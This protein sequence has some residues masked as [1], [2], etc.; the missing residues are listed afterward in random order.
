MNKIHMPNDLKDWRFDPITTTYE[1]AGYSIIVLRNP[2]EWSVFYK[3]ENSEA[4]LTLGIHPTPEIA[5]VV[6][7]KFRDLLIT[8]RH[9]TNQ[10]VIPRQERK[11]N[12]K[13]NDYRHPWDDTDCNR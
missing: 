2:E 6:C 12:E 1:W 3:V 4:M 13:V 9:Y 8:V 10:V 11:E 7:K 5:I